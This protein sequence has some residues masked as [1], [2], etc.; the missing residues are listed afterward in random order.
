[1]RS[2]S[3]KRARHSTAC[4]E[5]W[6]WAVSGAGQNDGRG[7][8]NRRSRQDHAEGRRE[9]LRATPRSCCVPLPLASS[10]C[11]LGR[12]RH[13]RGHGRNQMLDKQPHRWF[14][15]LACYAA[16]LKTLRHCIKRQYPLCQPLLS[17]GAV[18][19]VYLNPNEVPSQF[20][21]CLRGRPTAAEGVKHEVAGVAMI[22]FKNSSI[23]QP[24]RPS[25][26]AQGL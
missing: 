22:R 24:G 13:A 3:T 17:Y 5:P 23:I 15:E 1:M 20:L 4:S 21:R 26:E 2:I 12:L 9:M 25:A 8:R 14:I 10:R 6:L 19:R 7:N 18:I 16:V 11:P